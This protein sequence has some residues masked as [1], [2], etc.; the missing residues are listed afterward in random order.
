MEGNVERYNKK[1]K[2]VKKLSI[3]N[4]EEKISEYSVTSVCKQENG[5]L[6]DQEESN[7]TKFWEEE[8]ICERQ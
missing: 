1:C 8:T 5:V 3:R 2:E 6:K 4:S 7:N